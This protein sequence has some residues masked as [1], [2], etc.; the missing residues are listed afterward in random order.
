VGGGIVES[1]GV[2]HWSVR[3]LA[4]VAGAAAIATA[5]IEEFGKRIIIVDTRPTA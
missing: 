4:D 1:K 2:G 5:F 3:L